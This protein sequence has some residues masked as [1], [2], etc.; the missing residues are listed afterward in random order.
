VTEWLED[1]DRER[2]DSLG[3][4]SPLT[5]SAEAR[6]GREYTFSWSA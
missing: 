3:E 2:Y 1:Y 4:V 6:T 5:F